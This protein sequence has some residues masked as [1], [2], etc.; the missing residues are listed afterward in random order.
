MNSDRAMSITDFYTHYNHALDAVLLIARSNSGVERKFDLLIHT[1]MFYLHKM[2]RD[3]HTCNHTYR[4]TRLFLS[5]QT[6]YFSETLCCI[7]HLTDGVVVALV[8]ARPVKDVRGR[9]RL[10]G[11]IILCFYFHLVKFYH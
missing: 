10:K 8:I 6:H 7:C 9:V 1:C 3:M 5:S 11:G 4:H 2:K